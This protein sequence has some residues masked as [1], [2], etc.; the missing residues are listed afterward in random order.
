MPCLYVLLCGPKIRIKDS[1]ILYC[2]KEKK[3][4]GL[5]RASDISKSEV[6]SENCR[7][8][9]Y[10]D[11]TIVGSDNPLY[12][13]AAIYALILMHSKQPKLRWVLAVLS[14]IGLKQYK[15]ELEI[16]MVK[17]RVLTWL[18]NGFL[19]C[20]TE[21]VLILAMLENP[22]LPMGWDSLHKT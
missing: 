14:A 17:T 13:G 1:C 8:Q 20:E 11:E 6:L 21:F 22:I 4:S 10:Y 7:W 9:N 5:V 18:C 19:T 3:I 12:N 15:R 2:L 16:V